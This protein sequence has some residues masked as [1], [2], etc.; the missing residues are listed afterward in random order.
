MVSGVHVAECAPPRRRK[1]QG[2]I[3]CTDGSECE[4][5]SVRV[6]A[7]PSAVVATQSGKPTEC[8]R[9]L[10]T[11]WACSE[12]AKVTCHEDRVVVLVVT[13]NL[14]DGTSGTP[15]TNASQ[16]DT[17][18]NQGL[19]DGHAATIMRCNAGGPGERVEGYVH[20]V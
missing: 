5:L 16:V 15:M 19:D 12:P 11:F 14:L 4:N 8:S 10:P 3:D 1:C 9:D 20:M 17:F 13:P 18:A 6:A 2:L 7:H